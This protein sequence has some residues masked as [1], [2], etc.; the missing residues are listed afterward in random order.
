[1]GKLLHLFILIVLVF[2]TLS[3]SCNNSYMAEY[4]EKQENA[5]QNLIADL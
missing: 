3:L 4:I 2:S 1:M 5:T